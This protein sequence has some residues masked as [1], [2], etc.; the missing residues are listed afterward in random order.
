MKMV[1]IIEEVMWWLSD[2]VDLVIVMFFRVV[3]ILMIIVMKGVLMSLIR[4]V[5]RFIVVFSWLRK[6]LGLMLL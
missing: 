2:L 4:K 1:F 6:M 3:M 5:F